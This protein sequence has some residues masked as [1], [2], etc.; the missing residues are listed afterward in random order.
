[1]RAS[2]K[3]PI[4][5]F[6]VLVALKAG[7]ILPAHA[8]HAHH[9]PARDVSDSSAPSQRHAADAPLRE[10]MA[11]IHTAL[12]ELRHYE[13]GQMPEPLAIEQ[14]AA[15]KSAIDILFA[16][17][18]LEP[19]ADA[20]LHSILVPLLAAVQTFKGNPHDVGAI[21]AMRQAVADYSRLFDDSH[22]PLKAE[23]APDR[24]HSSNP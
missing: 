20:A 13:M 23:G 2:V 10:G 8:Q 9:E 6:T 7:V 19:E 3:L 1:M 5:V 4:S 17:C 22:W 15:I 14:V 21:A 12:D 18:K 11:R 24:T 16:T